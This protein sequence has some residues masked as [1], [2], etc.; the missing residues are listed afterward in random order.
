MAEW[1]ITN[2]DKKCCV[3]FISAY[4]QGRKEAP[5]T[6]RLIELILLGPAGQ[7]AHKRVLSAHAGIS[8]AGSGLFLGV[9]TGKKTGNNATEA[10]G[11]MYSYNNLFRAGGLRG[12]ELEI[13]TCFAC[14]VPKKMGELDINTNSSNPDGIS[15]FSDFKAKSV[16]PWVK[17]ECDK[18]SKLK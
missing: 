10:W 13:Y 14:N 7:K 16:I 12:M 6:P 11:G 15:L 9:A 17:S 8:S 3:D 2:P 18:N 1:Q 5:M 4:Y